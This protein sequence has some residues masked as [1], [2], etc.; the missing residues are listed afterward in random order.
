MAKEFSLKGVVEMLDKG[1]TATMTRLEDRT[2]R[3]RKAAAQVGGGFRQFNQGL[4]GLGAAGSVAGLGL[5]KAIST[6]AA[7]EQQMARSNALMRATKE[8]GMATTEVAK[9]LGATTEFTATQAAQGLEFLALAGFKAHDAIGVLPTILDTAT[10]GALDL[11]RASDIVTD[12]MSALG[13]AFDKNETVSQRAI[14]TADVMAKVQS[15]ANTNIEQLGEAIKFGAGGLTG[16]G[17]PLEAIIASMG[18]LA[19]AGLKGSIGGTSLMNMFNKIAKPSKKAGEFLGQFGL[20]VENLPLDNVPKLVSLINSKLATIPNK[21][22]RAAMAIELFGLR[23]IRAFN[24]LSNAG[25]ESLQELIGELENSEGFAKKIADIQRNTLQGTMK[26]FQSAA[27]AILIEFGNFFIKSEQ[28]VNEKGTGAF[29]RLVES[30]RDVAQAFAIVS[31]PAE[32]VNKQLAAADPKMRALIE[33]AMGVKEGFEAAF[34][35]TQKVFGFITEALKEFL[36]KGENTNRTIGRLVTQF[37][38]L[39]AAAAPLL[40]GFVAF[41]FVA[42]QVIT[43][44]AGI[45]NMAMGAI[46]MFGL[47]GKGLTFL[48]SGPIGWTIL[49]IGLLVAA[50]W[51]LVKNWDE[52]KA[53][54]ISTWNTVMTF[55]T[56]G[57]GETGH[58]IAFVLDT[59]KNHFM[60][61][62][63]NIKAIA[64]SVTEF[65]TAMME[66]RWRDAGSALGDIFTGIGKFWMDTLTGMLTFGGA[67]VGAI[68]TGLIEG[69]S[70]G[71]NWLIE[72]GPTLVAFF[73]DGIKNAFKVGLFVVTE[74]FD[75]FIGS[76]T[77]KLNGLIDKG[78]G[79]M[80]FLS[81][82]GEAFSGA[83]AF[84]G[85]GDEEPQ[86][87]QPRVL[88]PES[89]QP[90]N[91]R[92][93]S[94]ARSEQ[95]RLAVSKASEAPT[96]VNVSQPPIEA[97]F[98]IKT[99]I[100]GRE[101]SRSVAKQSINNSE[102]S[103]SRLSPREKNRMIQNGTFAAA[104]G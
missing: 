12:S 67:L 49:G 1:A 41:S 75:G 26:G 77:E 97:T 42:G 34:A 102:R 37:T 94:E 104:G 65:V 72:N 54:A 43:G 93:L 7:F 51:Y 2:K 13:A 24:A 76:V 16:F 98:N 96:T 63:N 90:Q 85:F 86:Q 87:Q 92:R 19:D 25:S 82:P 88:A 57:F 8:E 36:P 3:L 84:L 21:N 39:L 35:T 27:E 50:G 14:R 40:L 80:E 38:L 73:W 60:T 30:M 15:M 10:A 17:V 59:L 58:R 89:S 45:G 23:G 6:A 71:F 79:V 69:I 32:N 74:M 78:K 46:K 100:D 91:I 47:L 28:I 22:A 4:M 48:V 95:S 11:A 56:T 68:S 5:G 29:N 53:T 64:T 81:K 61:T 55:L 99:E 62:W 66:G 101:V 52:V 44:L 18:K 70:G 83:A 20:T 103:G 31:T 33:F 9:Q